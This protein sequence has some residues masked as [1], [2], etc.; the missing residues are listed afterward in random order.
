M[1]PIPVSHVSASV[2][3][4][5]DKCNSRED[6]GFVAVLDLFEKLRSG[7]PTLFK[8]VVV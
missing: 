7:P 4:V 1:L 8:N 6:A 3:D 2:A 5:S